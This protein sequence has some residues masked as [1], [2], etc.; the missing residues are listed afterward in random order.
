MN[1]RKES[2][3]SR[4]NNTTPC[5]K[6]W[7]NDQ[8]NAS[9]FLPDNIALPLNLIKLIPTRSLSS[10]PRSLVFIFARIYFSIVLSFSPSPST[11]PSAANICMSLS[12][13]PSPPPSPSLFSP[14]FL[15]LIRYSF[16]LFARS[17]SFLS[18]SHFPTRTY[19]LLPIHTGWGRGR[20]NETGRWDSNSRAIDYFPRR[21]G[22][23]EG[24]NNN[25]FVIDARTRL[26]PPPPISTITE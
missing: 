11:P 25:T 12:L 3:R 22:G 17:L 14:L 1:K 24:R 10:L 21:E 9:T 20:E 26:S 4:D 8:P 23:G 19:P 18:W 7:P 13:S 5:A 16:L 2:H 6:F 15:H